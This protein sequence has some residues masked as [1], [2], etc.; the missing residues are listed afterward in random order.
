[1][2]D[3][4]N[5]SCNVGCGGLVLPIAIGAVTN[6]AGGDIWTAAGIAAGV[7]GVHGAVCTTLG[8]VA[9]GIAAESKKV[10]LAVA[11]LGLGLTILGAGVGAGVSAGGHKL[12]D[13][14]INNMAQRTAIVQQAEEIQK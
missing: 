5:M 13:L 7:S 9:S 12:T 10:A 1:M 11:G 4:N 14:V 3:N 2:S 8:A 6:L